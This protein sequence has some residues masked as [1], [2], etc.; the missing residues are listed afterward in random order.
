MAKPTLSSL[1]TLLRDRRGNRGLREVAYEIAVSPATLS[2]VE[3]GKLPDLDTF[4]KICKWLRID[5]S[6]I[7]GCNISTTAN[8][9]LEPKVVYAHLRAEPNQTP[10]VAQA[11]ADMIMA[12]QRMISDRIEK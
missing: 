6:E 4:A 10:Q 7:L 12:A 8:S 3:N 11:L 1:G 5:A 9:Q 2:R